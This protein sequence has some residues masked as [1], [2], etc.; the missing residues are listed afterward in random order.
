[1][2]PLTCHDDS[3]HDFHTGEDNKYLCSKCNIEY[4]R[5][6]E[7]LT[8]R[9][10]LVNKIKEIIENTNAHPEADLAEAMFNAMRETHRTL[11]QNFI[12]SLVLFFQKMKDMPTD[13]RNEA[14]V[15][16]CKKVSEIEALLPKI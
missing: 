5:Y 7:A 1:M 2:Y 6:R 9:I 14:S 8:A 4:D 10:V 12:R 15:E 13:L 16:W 3:Q 11:Q